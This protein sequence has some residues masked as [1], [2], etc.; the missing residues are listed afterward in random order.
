MSPEATKNPSTKKLV[1]D[2]G[3]LYPLTLSGKKLMLHPIRLPYGNAGFTVA[4]L[5]IR[6]LRHK[7]LTGF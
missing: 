3:C 1:V 5:H 6:S 4:A 7:R 2:Y